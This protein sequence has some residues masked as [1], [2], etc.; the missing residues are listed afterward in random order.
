MAKAD[1][2]LKTLGEKK[3]AQTWPGC[4]DTSFSS[5]FSAS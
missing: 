2:R 3:H 4:L 1:V 5:D